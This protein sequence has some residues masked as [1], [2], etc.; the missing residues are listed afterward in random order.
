MPAKQRF[1]RHDSRDLPQLS[2]AKPIRSHGESAPIIIGQLQ[3]STPQLVANNTIL[4]E[5]ITKDVSLLVVQPPGEE[6]EQ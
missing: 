1:R 2:T 5:Q 3:A 4:F 6:R